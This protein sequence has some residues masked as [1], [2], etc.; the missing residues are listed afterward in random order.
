MVVAFHASTAVVLSRIHHMVS[1]R[2]GD[3]RGKQVMPPRSTSP[4]REG[5]T[6]PKDGDPLTADEVV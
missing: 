1:S 2:I 3:V 6:F 4:L 5:V